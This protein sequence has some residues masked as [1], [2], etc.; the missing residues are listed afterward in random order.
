MLKAFFFA[1]MGAFFPNEYY[2]KVMK[3]IRVG[4]EQISEGISLAILT[5]NSNSLLGNI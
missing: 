1:P 2:Q 3:G 4:L 5:Q